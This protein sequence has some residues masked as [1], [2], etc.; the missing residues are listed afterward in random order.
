MGPRGWTWLAVALSLP[1]LIPLTATLAALARPDSD[2]LH[3]LW[4]YVLPQ[5]AGNTAWLLLGVGAGTAVL[6]TALAALVA[7]CEFP[8][9]RWFSWLLVLPL[10]M[11]G[12]VLAVAFIGLF[13]YAAP[14]TSFLRDSVGTQL[15]DIRSRTGLIA[16]MTLALYPY[17]YL[18]AREAFASQGAR[19]MEA[20][21]AL[22]MGPWRAFWRASLPMARP[23]IA[24]GTLLVLMETLADFGA[25]SAFNYE[26]FTTA[27]YKA[28][29]ALFS[30][31]TAL[32]IAAVLLLGVLVLVGLEAA[33]RK[34][35]SFARVGLAEA[36][37]MPLGRRGWWATGGC[38]LVLFAALALPLSQLVWDGMA[39]LAD[40]DLRYFA[41]LRNALSLSAMA[42]VLTTIAA[43]V[44]ALAAREQP[45]LLTTAI[46]RVTTL[47]YGL[48]GALLAIGLY[49]PVAT[50]ST[51]LMDTR[52][53]DVPLEGGLLLLLVAYGIRFLAVAHTPVAG[54][55]LRIRPQLLEASRSLGVTGARQL[56]QVHWPLLRGSF[57]TAALLVFVDTMKEM[58]ITLMMRPFGWDT[59]ATRVFELTN[60]GEYARAALPSL[61]IA[62]AGLIPVIALTRRGR[63]A[64]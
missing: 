64:T 39:H 16:V 59:L 17:V 18:V 32:Q 31:D 26:T 62:L 34:R 20:A 35:Q 43:F 28:W 61:A 25:V 41:S 51:W 60:E 3:H 27:I 12:Y 2:T 8:G 49:V 5:V 55:L 56:R 15:P 11:P 54:G 10:A 36:A 30:T 4:Q 22:G 14:L 7:L 1:S 21:R 9:R 23:W 63:N 6:G 33:S 24:G 50:F 46:T 19:A 38:S 58:P 29:F 52:G 40:L 57:A 44:I 47:G 45:G 48:P 53:W 42:A 37:R 13:D